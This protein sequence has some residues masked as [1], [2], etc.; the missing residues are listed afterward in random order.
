MPRKRS[1]KTELRRKYE[2]EAK[3]ATTPGAFQEDMIDAV[4]LLCKRVELETAENCAEMCEGFV[5]LSRI[6]I[7]A[8]IRKKFGLYKQGEAKSR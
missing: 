6:E 5:G 8:Q 3:S 2:D 4:L 7:A 1:P